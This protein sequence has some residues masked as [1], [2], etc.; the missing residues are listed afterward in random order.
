MGTTTVSPGAEGL[1]ARMKYS[2]HTGITRWDCCCG[3][4]RIHQGNDCDN[5]AR[6]LR[7]HGIALGVGGDGYACVVDQ[8]A[9]VYKGVFCAAEAFGPIRLD[10]MEGWR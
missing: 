1:G 9:S 3:V 4:G 6:S 5:R 2:L 7:R 8:K 10:A